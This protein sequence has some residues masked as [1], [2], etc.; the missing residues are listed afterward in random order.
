MTDKLKRAIEKWRA[1][2]TEARAA[3]HLLTQAYDDVFAKKRRLVDLP[4]IH[5]CQV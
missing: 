4:L 1:A 5:Y 3:E 2:D